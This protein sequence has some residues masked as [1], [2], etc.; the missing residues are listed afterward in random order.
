MTI[1]LGW[2]GLVR[3]A[4]DPVFDAADAGFSWNESGFSTAN[5]TMLWEA[6]ALV[7]AARYPDSRVEESYGDSWPP[8]CIDYWVHVD[9]SR[10]TAR[11][12]VEGWS[13]DVRVLQ[14]TGSGGTDG[15]LLAR[16]FG[17]ILRVP[18][19]DET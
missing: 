10:L 9:P 15:R 11:L 2:F 3:A 17:E 12:D 14:L 8:P 1:D 7:F 19:G 6:D 5:H 18:L 16:A 13:G 4:C